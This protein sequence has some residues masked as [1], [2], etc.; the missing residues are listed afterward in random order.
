MRAVRLFRIA[1]LLRMV[2]LATG[3]RKILFSLVISLPAIFNIAVLLFLIVFIYAVMGMNL[4]GYLPYQGVINDVINF[5][6]FPNALLLMFRLTTA[7]SWDAVLESLMVSQ[8]T[9]D[10]DYYTMPDGRVIQASGGSCVD[11]VLAI[12]FIVSYIA[13]VYLIITNMYVAIILE[14]FEMATE[15]E[16]IGVTDDDF[17]LF[18][19]IWEKYDPHATQFIKYE[20]LSDFIGELDEPLGIPKA[21][22]NSHRCFRP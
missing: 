13:L 21:Q 17:E 2:K 8:P 5:Q 6:T 14:N 12:I 10:P 22:R 4:F 1:R 20:K 15:E 18:Y 11:P 7:V 19:F 16:E 3:I 9:C